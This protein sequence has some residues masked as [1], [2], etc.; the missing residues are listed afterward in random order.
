MG[1][2]HEKLMSGKTANGT[3]DPQITVRI[4]FEQ[5]IK[6]FKDITLKKL[7]MKTIRKITMFMILFFIGIMVFATDG[8]AEAKQATLKTIWAFIQANGWW[9]A[10]ALLAISEGLA[11]SK[12]KSNSIYQLIIGW[13]K[14]KSNKP[15]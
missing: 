15:T 13:L 11:S 12:L 4:K 1:R 10:T 2:E 3:T 9:I 6:L 8:E 5:I 7:S 14:K